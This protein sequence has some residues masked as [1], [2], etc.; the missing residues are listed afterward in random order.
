MNYKIKINGAEYEVHIRKVED[1][2]ACVT[3]NNEEFE[4]EV[5]GLKVNP[6]RLDTRTSSK[7]ITKPIPA[8]TQVVKPTSTKYNHEVRPPLPGIILDICVKEG[9]KVKKGQVL[10]VLEAMKM[11]NH[12]ESDFDG[13]VE[14]ICRAKGESVLENDVLLIIK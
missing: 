4:V 9:E 2:K 7:L 1:T 13:I 3:V 14:K 6:K 8:N 10:Y 12:I 11:E 5:E